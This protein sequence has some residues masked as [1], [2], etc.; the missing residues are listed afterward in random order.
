MN[1]VDPWPLTRFNEDNEIVKDIAFPSK[2]PRL[3]NPVSLKQS[4]AIPL[5]QGRLQDMGSVMIYRA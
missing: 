3:E 5:F 2:N 4:H 1:R